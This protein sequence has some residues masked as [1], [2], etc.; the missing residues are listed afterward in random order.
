MHRHLALHAEIF[1]RAHESIAKKNLPRAVRGNARNQ[2]IFCGKQPLRKTESVAWRIGRERRKKRRR[3]KL[4]R[5]CGSRV[6]AARKHMGLARHRVAHHHYPR[7]LVAVE[8]VERNLRAFASGTH[9]RNEFVATRTQRVAGV[10][11]HR[12]RNADSARRSIDD[13]RLGHAIKRVEHRVVVALRE[14]VEFVIVTLRA[15]HREAEPGGGRCIDTVE[16]RNEAVFLRNRAAFSVEKMVAVERCCKARLV[17]G[18]GKQIASDHLGRQS[19]VRRVAVE[20]AHQP[21]APQ[22]LEGIAV[23]LKSVGVGV[24]RG[25]EPRQRHLLAVMR[26]SEKP[27]DHALVGARTVVGEK[28]G[29]FLGRRWQSHQIKRDSAQ[30]RDRRRL[31]RRRKA[32]TRKPRFHDCVDGMH[33]KRCRRG[34]GRLER[35]VLFVHRARIDPTRQQRTLRIGERLM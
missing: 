5:F 10:L 11:K 31:G 30:Q 21:V 17:G 6:R 14:R 35:P 8:V 28:V 13:P 3:C 27:I 20:L 2:G 23:L 24:A 29:D 34:H 9:H 18:V 15:R 7:P 32:R 22:P 33:A 1:R 12:R 16:Q 4:N 25:I 19:V 26:A